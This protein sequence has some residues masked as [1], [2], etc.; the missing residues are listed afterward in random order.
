LNFL[1]NIIQKDQELFIF[2][3]ALGSE[4]WDSFWLIITNQFS[5]LPL[6]LVFFYMIFRSY[7]W[8]KAIAL[9]V[10]TTLLITFSD[11][12]V[13]FIKNFFQRLRPNNDPSIN[14]IIRVV[15][16]SGGYSFVSGHATTSVAVSLFI[17]LTLRKY[18]K[19]IFLI[20]FWPLLFG[21]SRI[22]V[23]VHFPTDVLLGF[24]LGAIIGWIFYKLSLLIIKKI[25]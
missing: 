10:F 11:Q 9:L 21:Y 22:Y 20:F 5:W 7:G 24:L 25:N 3:N 6:Y 1:E 13:N 18:Y 19:Y 8:K 4:N 17:F 12:F 2:L 14:Q 15:K 16:N 23:G